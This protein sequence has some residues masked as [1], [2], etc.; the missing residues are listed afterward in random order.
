MI[1]LLWIMGLTLAPKVKPNYLLESEESSAAE[2]E[3]DSEK[4]YEAYKALSDKYAVT[5]GTPTPGQGTP[6][7]GQETPTPG[8][9]TPTPGQE[10]PT[11]GQETP[12][13]GQETP[14]PGQE[15]PTP[16]QETPTPG[17]ETPTPGQETPTPGQET[18]T[19][20]QDTPTPEGETPTPEGGVQRMVKKSGGK[21]GGYR[22]K[23][24][25][26]TETQLLVEFEKECKATAAKEAC[27]S[28]LPKLKVETPTNSDKA[29]F[30]DKCKVGG[31]PVEDDNGLPVSTANTILFIL[32]FAIANIYFK[33]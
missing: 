13:P 22:R 25:S 9:E 12:T 24:L 29:D 2:E 1:A 19:P 7:P 3:V 17:Q 33:L 11:P 20:G 28:L 14:T 18:P 16:G 5:P 4:C 31:Q 6:T 27:S 21:L 26:S 10:T 23:L 30:A 32:S 15:T 8:Q